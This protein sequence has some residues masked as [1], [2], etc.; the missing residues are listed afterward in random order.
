MPNHI[1]HRPPA[2]NSLGVAGFV[3][4]LVGILS[5]GLLAPIGM[6]MSYVAMRRQS[7]GL[8]I[9]GFVIGLVGS[10]WLLVAL[11]FGL[12]GLLLAALGIAAA[13]SGGA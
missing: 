11:I 4:S 13:A 10:L 2:S 5:C 3:V 6:V 1:S 7:D 12:F 8:A 9:A